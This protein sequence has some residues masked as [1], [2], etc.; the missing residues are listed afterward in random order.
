MPAGVCPRCDS[1]AY[2][3]TPQELAKQKQL[4]EAPP[5]KVRVVLDIEIP[6][7]A[8]HLMAY[9]N[10]NNFSPEYFTPERLANLFVSRYVLKRDEAPE[11]V[12]CF[13]TWKIEPRV[14]VIHDVITTDSGWKKTTTQAPTQQVVDGKQVEVQVTVEQVVE[15]QVITHDDGSALMRNP[16]DKELPPTGVATKAEITDLLKVLENNIMERMKGL[17][18]A[19][20]ANY[21]KAMQQLLQDKEIKWLAVSEKEMAKVVPAP[22]VTVVEP[23]PTL[24]E[25]AEKWARDW[26]YR[27]GLRPLSKD[28]VPPTHPEQF[29]PGDIIYAKG[30]FESDPAKMFMIVKKAT[31]KKLTYFSGYFGGGGYVCCDGDLNPPAVDDSV[32]DI[33][34][35]WFDVDLARQNGPFSPTNTI[36][37]HPKRLAEH[38]K[39]CTA[40]LAVSEV[41]KMVKDI[42]RVAHHLC[43]CISRIASTNLIKVCIKDTDPSMV[44]NTYLLPSEFFGL[45][46]MNDPQRRGR[47][48][49]EKK[50]TAAAKAA[51]VAMDD[52]SKRAKSKHPTA[53]QG[54]LRSRIVVTGPK[55]KFRPYPVGEVLMHRDDPRKIFIVNSTP[56][57]RGRVFGETRIIFTRR[58]GVLPFYQQ[59]TRKDDA[60]YNT[61]GWQTAPRRPKLDDKVILDPQ[62]V[63]KHWDKITKKMA[64]GDIARLFE[65]C[66]SLT[67]DFMKVIANYLT[68]GREHMVQV[69]CGANYSVRRDIPRAFLSPLKQIKV[70]KQ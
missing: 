3:A 54:I 62:R 24:R 4:S 2:L 67:G 48:A 63:C 65:L 45:V 61:T 50:P 34:H 56:Q 60:V 14:E 18:P 13:K 59:F 12:E 47:I 69:G 23:R 22:A 57:T 10:E 19:E 9:R 43:T 28:Q 29:M 41:A 31:K 51:K 15:K 30:I 20:A 55:P 52:Y 38:W 49:K 40:S 16:N 5:S 42:K 11:F 17:P 64:K 53:K 36:L 44:G 37:L 7:I 68:P 6:A 33:G 39:K 21:S 26:R 70:P 58:R 8:K 46:V 66:K 27:Q 32:L 35:S 1:L 25:K